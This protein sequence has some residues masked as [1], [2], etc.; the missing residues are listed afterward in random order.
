[1]AKLKKVI[2]YLIIFSLFFSVQILAKEDFRVGVQVICPYVCTTDL[3]SSEEKGYLIEILDQFMQARGKKLQVMFLPTPRR[4]RFFKEHRVDVIIVISSDIEKLR[5]VQSLDIPLGLFS[6]GIATQKTDENLYLTFDDL[7]GKSFFYSDGLFENFAGKEKIKTLG[8]K[9]IGLAGEGV[10]RRLLKILSHGRADIVGGDY[11]S[12]KYAFLKDKE[13]AK[14]LKVIP[15]SLFGHSP[16][17]FAV[18]NDFPN[19]AGFEKDFQDFLEKMRSSGELGQLL[20][21][22]GLSD[23]ANRVGR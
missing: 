2:K 5:F 13:N 10:H 7:K 16:L 22:Y 18:S 17:V 19:K 20:R 12:L 6:F 8:P 23:W 11:N 3:E 9:A 1:M 4:A 21:K 14:T 15:T